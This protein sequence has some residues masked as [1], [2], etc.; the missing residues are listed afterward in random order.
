M[1]ERSAAWMAGYE[2]GREAYAPAAISAI[3]VPEAHQE[4]AAD[5]VT[6][7]LCGSRDAADQGLIDD[8]IGNLSTD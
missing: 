6:G 5:F 7:F 2:A 4:S 8:I 1:A 3:V